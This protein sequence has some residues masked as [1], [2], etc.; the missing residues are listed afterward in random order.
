MSDETKSVYTYCGGGG[1]PEGVVDWDSGSI[2]YLDKAEKYLCLTEVQ[3]PHDPRMG[4]CTEHIEIPVEVLRMLLDRA[5][6][7]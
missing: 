2:F 3:E 7:K 1:E 5:G 6:V 4:G